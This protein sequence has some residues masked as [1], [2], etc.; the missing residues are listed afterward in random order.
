MQKESQVYHQSDLTRWHPAPISAYHE[1]TIKVTSQDGIRHLSQPITRRLKTQKW[2]N[3]RTVKGRWYANTMKFKV[4]SI[5]RNN[6]AAQ[7]FTNGKGCVAFYPVRGDVRCHVGL[8]C[9]INELGIPAAHLVTDGAKAQ[10]N[11]ET[12]NTV[13]D[14][15]RSK[16][17]GDLRRAIWWMTSKKGSPRRCW[18]FCGSMLAAGRMNL[19]ASSD[20]SS[21]GRTSFELVHGYT[22]DITL[23]MIHD[24]WYDFIWWYNLNEKTNWLG[25]WLGPCGDTFGGSNCQYVLFKTGKVHITKSMRAILEDECCHPDI[26]SQLE[27]HNK[28]INA[29]IGDEVKPSDTYLENELGKPPLGLFDG[30]Y[31]GE[32][33]VLMAEAEASSPDIQ[34]LTDKDLDEYLGSEVLLQIG[35]QRIWGLVKSRSRDA[36][37][38]LIGEKNNNSLLDSRSYE[39]S[40]PDGSIETYTAIML[41][42]SIYSSVDD[43]GRMFCLLDEIINFERDE[44]ALTTEQ[45][46]YITKSGQTRTKP[47]PKGGGSL[48]L[49]DMK[50]SFPVE[51]ATYAPRAIAKEMKNSSRFHWG[52]KITMHKRPQ[53][54]R[55]Y[56]ICGRHGCK[57]D[58]RKDVTVARTSRPQGTKGRKDVAT[59]TTAQKQRNSGAGRGRGSTTGRGHG[60]TTGHS[61]GSTIGRGGGRGRG[62]GRGC[63]LGALAA[64]AAA[65]AA[66]QESATARAAAVAAEAAWAA[67]IFNGTGRIP[68]AGA[69]AA[70]TTTR[71]RMRRTDLRPNHILLITENSIN[72]PTQ[73][74]R[75][76]TIF[77]NFMEHKEGHKFADDKVFTI[78]EKAARMEKENPTGNDNPTLGR[79]STL[80]YYKKAISQFMVSQSAWYEATLRG[81]PMKSRHAEEFVQ[82]VDM[83]FTQGHLIENLRHQAMLKFQLHLI[84]RMDDT[85]HVQKK[86]L[87]K[88]LQFPQYLC[89]RLKWCKNAQD[90]RN[91]PQQ[92]LIG[93]M[94]AKYCVLGGLTMFLE[95]WLASG[96]GVTSQ[97]LFS[98]GTTTPTDEEDLKD[99][100]ACRQKLAY[101]NAVLVCIKSAVFEREGPGKLG[102]HSIGKYGTSKA[103]MSGA[104]Y[105][106]VDCRTRWKNPNMQ[107]RYSAVQLDWPDITAAVKLCGGGP[108]IYKAVEGSGV[109]NDWLGTNVVPAIKAQFGPG[110]ARVFGLALLLVTFDAHASDLVSPDIRHQVTAKYIQLEAGLDDGVNPVKKVM[111]FA[112]EHGGCVSLDEIE[113]NMDDLMTQLGQQWRNSIYA[114]PSSNQVELGEPMNFVIANL[115]QPSWQNNTIE[116]LIHHLAPAPARRVGG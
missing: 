82:I 52:T 18:A 70:A 2:R 35:D 15:L 16:S 41:A 69:A 61:R 89:I 48:S 37:G 83:I 28:D 76:Y 54:T 64:A 93:S 39:V 20:P 72:A 24:W 21:M 47:Q 106:D 23:Y 63:G 75:Y 101:A 10:G 116:R 112:S 22:P 97:W 14:K 31:E 86:N 92:L 27:A 81:D 46:N 44:K 74:K 60:S 103:Q 102:T 67:L 91:C 29:K 17:A 68:G 32:D 3:R 100:E 58:G 78:E 55:L 11:H 71:T 9:F 5:I 26:L 8:S 49:S 79:S 88:S 95:K 109:T 65:A 56:A 51:T 45:A 13:W 40:M 90:E 98:D 96:E 34:D 19:M 114:K 4:P 87:Q 30:I 85:A 111:I 12:H 73:L 42:E 62:R 36:N 6:T 1:N 104:K 105:Q 53:A 66:A 108:C 99:E 94:N 50:E 33:E 80:V 115:A 84:A 43:K 7:V 38:V 107:G 25:R 113:D 59:T 77:C 57:D 110:V